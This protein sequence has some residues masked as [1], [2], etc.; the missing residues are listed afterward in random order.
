MIDQSKLTPQRERLRALCRDAR[1]REELA[2]YRASLEVE[3]RPEPL[4]L[5]NRLT[6]C[7]QWNDEVNHRNGW[8]R[9]CPRMKQAAE[10][11]R[12]LGWR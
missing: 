9:P 5:G 3:H 4:K 7:C 11:S 2:A 12:I 1:F 8:N 6:T 10:M